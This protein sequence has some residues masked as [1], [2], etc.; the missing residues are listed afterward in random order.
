MFEIL[1]HFPYFNVLLLHV[2]VKSTKVLFG[3]PIYTLQGVD[4]KTRLS[5]LLS[6]I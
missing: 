3:W 6:Q 4:K 1:E 2:D 5:F